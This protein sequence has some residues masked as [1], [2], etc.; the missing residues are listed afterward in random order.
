MPI[1]TI[2][3]HPSPTAKKL[4]GLAPDRV[5]LGGLSGPETS[6]LVTDISKSLQSGKSRNA[7]KVFSVVT[8]GV[9]PYF[10]LPKKRFRVETLSEV[11]VIF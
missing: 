5:G 8:E 7:A 4:K 11:L 10:A 2:K 9:L 6:F 3:M 1:N